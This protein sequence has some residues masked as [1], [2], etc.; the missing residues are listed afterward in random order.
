VVSR[1]TLTGGYFLLPAILPQ[2]C[3]LLTSAPVITEDEASVAYAV[4][5]TVAYTVV[6]TVAYTVVYTVVYTAMCS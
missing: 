5:Y 6:Y 1:T 3:P 4:V 2:T